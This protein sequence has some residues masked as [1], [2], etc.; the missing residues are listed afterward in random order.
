MNNY[1]RSQQ[2]WASQM[3]Q[4]QQ[5]QQSQPPSWQQPPQQQ[6]PWSGVS[7]GYSGMYD[8]KKMGNRGGYSGGYAGYNS[9]MGQGSS[10]HSWAG[11]RNNAQYQSA[12]WEA[13]T[14][15]GSG[16]GTSNQYRPDWQPPRESETS[17]S[18]S[19]GMQP[20]YDSWP[21]C[22]DD[23]EKYMWRDPKPKKKIRDSGTQVWGD[24]Q[25]Q[26]DKILRWKE[27]DHEDFHR[28]PSSSTW[29]QLNFNEDPQAYKD[30]FSNV[31]KSANDYA[32]HVVTDMGE[33]RLYAL[34]DAFQIA[35]ANGYIP[36]EMKLSQLDQNQKF[37]VNT[38]LQ[39]LIKKEQAEQELDHIRK[40]ITLGEYQPAVAQEHE[41]ISNEHERIKRDLASISEELKATMQSTSY[42]PWMNSQWQKRAPDH[43]ADHLTSA[44]QGLGITE[45]FPGVGTWPMEGTPLG[46]TTPPPISINTDL[47]KSNNSTN[48][49]NDGNTKEGGGPKEFVPGRRWEWNDPAKVAEDPNATPGSVKLSFGSPG[50]VNGGC[51][52]WNKPPEKRSSSDGSTEK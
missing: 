41:R 9:A 42:T 27:A 5:Y 19:Q 33:P 48:P 18:G 21:T 46:W 3:A 52:P 10:H 36:D 45:K 25:A 44:L 37:L 20:R 51:D 1:G 32:E 39:K 6:V 49:E 12:P 38:L 15:N 2:Q 17:T 14:A 47:E 11:Q 29:N 34:N 22:G 40:I 28:G 8:D 30:S 35:M 23:A 50:W 13:P 26:Q 24:P 16:W 4:W 43:S 31:A 7:T